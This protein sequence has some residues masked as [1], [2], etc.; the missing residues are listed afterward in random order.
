[1]SLPGERQSEALRLGD[2]L[3]ARGSAANEANKWRRLLCGTQ[4]LSGVA[5]VSEA[6]IGREV[7][8]VRTGA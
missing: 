5:D 1:L 2:F 8:A 7:T 6:D 3:I 4:S